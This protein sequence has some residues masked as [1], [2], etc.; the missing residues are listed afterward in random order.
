MSYRKFYYFSPKSGS[1]LFTDFLWENTVIWQWIQGGFF[2]CFCL[3]YQEEKSSTPN[4]MWGKWELLA[5]VCT[6]G[7]ST[8]LCKIRT[9]PF[10]DCQGRKRETRGNAN[11][12]FLV[13]I[14]EPPPAPLRLYHAHNS[15]PTLRSC[16]SKSR[17]EGTLYQPCE[18]RQK[19]PQKSATMT[20]L[21]SLLC[22]PTFSLTAPGTGLCLGA[23]AHLC[24]HA[25]LLTTGC[26]NCFSRVEW[27]PLDDSES[28]LPTFACS[29]QQE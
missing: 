26:F 4:Q 3:T 7:L 16:R 9:L 28:V 29:M 27:K 14:N 17:G 18:E 19:T 12:G 11:G 21:L 2:C 25:S 13:H 15:K 22:R 8:L 10:D 6:T 1:C 5:N 23:S 24:I 20:D